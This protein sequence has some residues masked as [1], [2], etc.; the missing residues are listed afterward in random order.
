[1]LAWAIAAITGTG[2]VEDPYRAD[3]PGSWA[4]LIPTGPD[5]RPIHPWAIGA[6]PAAEA[7]AV[8]ARPDAAA[9]TDLDALVPTEVLVRLRDTGLD[10]IDPDTALTARS[11]LAAAFDRLGLTPRRLRVGPDLTPEVL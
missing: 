6:V 9:F 5:G 8:N 4:G 1:M 3:L 7:S 2:T 10:W 11:L